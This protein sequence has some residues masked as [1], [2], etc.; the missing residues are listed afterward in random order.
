MRFIPIKR[1]EWPSFSPRYE[2]IP[3]QDIY[4][5]LRELLHTNHGYSGSQVDQICKKFLETTFSLWASDNHLSTPN[6]YTQDPPGKMDG[7]RKLS[8]YEKVL[9]NVIWRDSDIVLLFEANRVPEDKFRNL[10]NQLLIRLEQLYPPTGY[11][12]LL[13]VR[14]DVHQWQR[15]DMIVYIR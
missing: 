14:V 1:E 12:S 8:F 5:D 3:T 6:H 11:E 10:I 4:D 9:D 2:A 13:D 15:H 7:F